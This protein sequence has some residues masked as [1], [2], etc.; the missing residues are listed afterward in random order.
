MAGSAE[1]LPG[2]PALVLLLILLCK[3]NGGTLIQLPARWQEEHGGVCPWAVCPSLLSTGGS[4]RR[5]G[6]R[7]RAASR[8]RGAGPGL[9]KHQLSGGQRAR[10][11]MASM[12]LSISRPVIAELINAGRYGLAR[13][14]GLLGLA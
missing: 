5:D 13:K 3:G 12:D 4:G 2:H 14:P 10:L 1:G 9:R 8:S 6:E 7:A 11:G